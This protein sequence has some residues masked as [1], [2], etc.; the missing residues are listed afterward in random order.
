[1]AVAVYYRRHPVIDKEPMVCWTCKH[2]WWQIAKDPDPD[3][4]NCG[5]VNTHYDKPDKP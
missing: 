3:C 2:R 4:P 5:S 1:M